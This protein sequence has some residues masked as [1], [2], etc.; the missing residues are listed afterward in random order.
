MQNS[1]WHAFDFLAVETNRV[2]AK[3]SKL[4]VRTCHIFGIFWA[5]PGHILVYWL[6]HT[7]FLQRKANWRWEP[8]ISLGYFGHILVTY[9]YIGWDKLEVRSKHIGTGKEQL[10][11]PLKFWWCYWYVSHVFL[12]HID[13][14]CSQYWGIFTEACRL[15][16]FRL[17]RDSRVFFAAKDNTSGA[18]IYAPQIYI[19]YM[20]IRSLFGMGLWISVCFKF[21]SVQPVIWMPL[22]TTG[23][24]I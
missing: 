22:F 9:W 13:L 4:K 23:C 1:I 15:C 3:K 17:L 7:E 12:W 5:Y 2:S 14:A 18:R 6:R 16:T 24:V 21:A 19:V 10:L 20:Q 8:A 11:Q